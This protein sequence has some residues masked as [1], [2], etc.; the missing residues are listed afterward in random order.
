[1]PNQ[2]FRQLNSPLSCIR[3]QKSI[4]ELTS[5]HAYLK[6][7]F[8]RATESEAF[9]LAKTPIGALRGRKE[10]PAHERRQRP[11]RSSTRAGP[12]ED[13]SSVPP[14]R[15]DTAA[16]SHVRQ[17]GGQ[18]RRGTR[19]R[20]RQLPQLTHMRN[21]RRHRCSMP[22]RIERS[23]ARTQPVTSVDDP[24]PLSEFKAVAKRCH[25]RYCLATRPELTAFF[26]KN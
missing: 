25:F 8:T 9:L 11:Y 15:L 16:P 10:T 20:L 22:F 13:A 17:S 23:A 12:W 2:V 18:G 19:G 6:P 24:R 5:T 1:M 14:T 21:K 26:F 7:D 3:A 4:R